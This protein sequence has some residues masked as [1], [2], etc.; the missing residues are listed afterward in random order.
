[1]ISALQET[2]SSDVQNLSLLGVFSHNGH[3]IRG[4]RSFFCK[5]QRSWRS[6]ERCTAVL[7]ESVVVMNVTHLTPVKTWRIMSSSSRRRH[8]LNRK[9]AAQE[10]KSFTL[11]VISVWSWVYYVLA[12]T[13]TNSSERCTGPNVG[14][15]AKLIHG[16]AHK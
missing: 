11:K 5:L 8:K 2:R 10:T 16:V 6:E 14:W 13:M 9:D 4:V 7:F 3:H 15:V 1:M 12:M